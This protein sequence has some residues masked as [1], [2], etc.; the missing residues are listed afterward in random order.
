MDIKNSAHWRVRVFKKCYGA[1]FIDFSYPF[2]FPWIA[3]K[4]STTNVHPK[5]VVGY[6]H[7]T[8]SVLALGGKTE[9]NDRYTLIN[10]VPKVIRL[11][12]VGS[13]YFVRYRFSMPV[14]NSNVT[15]WE[16]AQ[17]DPVATKQE[18]V[19]TKL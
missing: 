14:G 4:A 12:D 19:D 7:Q 18:E 15:I 3:I 13:P 16:Y 5:N 9:V 11:E 2:S 17:P 10:D 1:D 8:I 6:I